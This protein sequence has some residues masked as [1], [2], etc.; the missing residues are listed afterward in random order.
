MK[1]LA[2]RVSSPAELALDCSTVWPVELPMRCSEASLVE[3]LM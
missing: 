2:Y 3:R 1:Y